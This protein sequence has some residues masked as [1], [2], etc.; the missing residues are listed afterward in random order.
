M[1]RSATP[2]SE[3]TPMSQP[4]VKT[5]IHE[6]TA[7]VILNRPEKRNALS[8]ALLA[9][10][11]GALEELHLDRQVRA[12]VIAGSGSAFCAG[13]DLNEMLETSQS[14]DA[15]ERWHSDAVLYRDLL[16]TMLQFPKPLIAAV[17][18]PALAGGAGLVLSCDIVIAADS[19]TFGVPEPRR[20]LVAGIVAP[21]LAFRVGGGRAGYL[22]MSA[23]PIDAAEALRMGVF[24]EVV[25][26]D[27][28]WP[29]ANHLAKQCAASSPEALLLTKRVLSETIGEQLFT[30]LSA[31]AAVSATARTTLAAAEGLKAFLEKR[32]P[33]WQ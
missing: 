23:T 18:G 32:E 30:Q 27:H 4:L 29:R 26:A 25:K 11:A 3:I 22:L 24:H 15:A 9:D 7:T 21:L 20:G 2:H 33:N 12:I 5:H 6:S 31:G 14:P 13:M 17:G 28:L 1:F 19:A 10:L 8:R 16:E